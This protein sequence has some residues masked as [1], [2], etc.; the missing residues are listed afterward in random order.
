M[1]EF[2]KWIQSV[3]ERIK[4]LEEKITTDNNAR[5]EICPTCRGVGVLDL[6]FCDS[7]C[8]V[9]NGTGKLSPVA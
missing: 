8:H 7:E 3:E 6:H 4:M 9:C 5:A 2:A 1:E